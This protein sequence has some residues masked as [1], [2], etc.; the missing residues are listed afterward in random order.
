MSN[1]FPG[2]CNLAYL[3]QWLEWGGHLSFET[4]LIDVSRSPFLEMFKVHLV[5]RIVIVFDKVSSNMVIPLIIQAWRQWCSGGCHDLE[6][7]QAVV[8]EGPL[9]QITTCLLI[10]T[11]ILIKHFDCVHVLLY[12][13]LCCYWIYSVISENRF[14]LHPIETCTF[15]SAH[16]TCYSNFEPCFRIPPFPW[17]VL[18]TQSQCLTAPNP[19]L[20]VCT[21]SR[22]T[23]WYHKNQSL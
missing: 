17:T 2:N 21:A 16:F 5:F 10:I 3:C 1:C 12:P 15:H 23:T 8:G 19:A 13:M 9:W 14:N 4:Y 18:I 6:Q 22:Q 11:T 20:Q 7:L